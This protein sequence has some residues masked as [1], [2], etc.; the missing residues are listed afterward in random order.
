[1]PDENKEGWESRLPKNGTIAMRLEPAIAE[2]IAKM[3]WENGIKTTKQAKLILSAG[4]TAMEEGG[5][6]P[7][8]AV[9]NDQIFKQVGDIPADVVD[10]LD[11]AAEKHGRT[12]QAQAQRSLMDGLELQDAIS[13]V[14]DLLAQTPPPFS[15]VDWKPDAAE[16]LSFIKESIAAGIRKRKHRLALNKELEEVY[17]GQNQVCAICGEHMELEEALRDY[18]VPLSE[19]GSPTKDNVQV[20]CRDCNLS[21]RDRREM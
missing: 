3:A 20:I 7:E 21:K 1:M 4:L 6:V 9:P 12:T 13:A 16:C 8:A 15:E 19:G 10:R 17:D 18:I 14:S 5:E 11:A 2:K